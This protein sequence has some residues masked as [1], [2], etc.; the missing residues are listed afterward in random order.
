MS[1][2][3]HLA[4][5]GLLAQQA[6]LDTVSNDLAN[7]NTTGYKR[8][9]VAFQE[10][11]VGE[12][13]TAKGS[14]VRSLDGG[15][16][17]Q[18]GALAESSNRFALALEG[19]GFFQVKRGDGTLALSRG[20]EFRLDANGTF[21]LPG[22]E[23]LEP[24]VTVP[25]GVG[26]SDVSVSADGTVT[27]GGKKIGQIA[28]VDVPAPGGLLQQQGLAQPTAASGQPKPVPGTV[29]RQG[30]VEAS[31]VDV[32]SAMVEMIEAQR[33]FELASRA[34]RTHDQL[35]ETANGIRR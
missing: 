3:L 31:N 2:G 17:F 27:A 19:P 10:V 21:V 5:S 30:Y 35:L 8:A 4:A 32:A 13:V 16:S 15:R 18:Q 33:G 28:V 9:R 29:V 23:R 14:G 6:R 24:P 7:A 11:V 22:G 25:N 12:G 34:I 1:N 20:G 26:A